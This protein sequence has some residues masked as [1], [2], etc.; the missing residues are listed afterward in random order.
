MTRQPVEK[1]KP[2]PGWEG[3]YKVSSLGRVV[4][5]STDRFL[6]PFER[7]GYPRVHLR[8]GERDQFVDVHL[9]VCRAFHGEPPSPEM[10]AA[11]RNG[12]RTDCR[13]ANLQWKTPVENCADKVRHGTAP[14]GQ[15]NPRAKL[16]PRKAKRLRDADPDELPKLAKRYGIAVATARKVKAGES[17][18]HL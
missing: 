9:L 3:I 16:T 4:R 17:W 15:K 18:S 7:R 8:D 10:Q 2:A 14:I 6:R 1:W 5:V 11:H 13:S 12:V